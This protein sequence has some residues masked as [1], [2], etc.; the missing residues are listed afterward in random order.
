M[1]LTIFKNGGKE[2]I[3]VDCKC[4]METNASVRY[5]IWE[6]KGNEFIPTQTIR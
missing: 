5:M 3:R 4:G 2:Y 6:R 1:K